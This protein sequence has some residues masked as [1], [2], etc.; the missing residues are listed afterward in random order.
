MAKVNVSIPDELLSEV[1]EL[2]EELHRSRSG[3]VKEATAQY[4]TR[5]REDQATAERKESIEGAMREGIEIGRELGHFDST[6]TIRTDR[7]R[8]GRKAGEQ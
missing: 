8:D 4:V 6:T 2:A 3:L 1:D 7:D 5:I